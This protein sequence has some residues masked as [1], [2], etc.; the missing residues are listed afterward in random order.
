MPAAAQMQSIGQSDRQ[1]GSTMVTTAPASEREVLIDVQIWGQ[2]NR[3]GM[4]KVPVATDVAGLISY[5]NGPTEYAALSRVKLVRGGAPRGTA[6]KLNLGTFTGSGDR[7][8][9]PMLEAGDVVIVP[10]TYTHTLAQFTGF[11]SQV[12]VVVSAYLVIVGK[13]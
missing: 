7:A 6:I 3:A 9:V 13:R 8:Q 5:A 4:Y 2:V 12:V 1:S 11:I 10:T